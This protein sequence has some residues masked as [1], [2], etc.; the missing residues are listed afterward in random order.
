MAE[1]PEI[2]EAVAKAGLP[3]PAFE[4]YEI[5]SMRSTEKLSEHA[6]IVG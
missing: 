3:A 2:R 5:L 4:G 6:T 1:Y